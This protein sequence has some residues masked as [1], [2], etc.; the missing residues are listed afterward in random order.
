MS[1]L[2]YI[3]KIPKD[4]KV[5]ETD[6][7][8]APRIY[9]ARIK[10]RDMIRSGFISSLSMFIFEN[11]IIDS[12]KLVLRGIDRSGDPVWELQVE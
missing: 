4:W 1:D 7:S 11:G 5:I 9:L 12:T 2:E 10:D 6:E 3:S 8:K